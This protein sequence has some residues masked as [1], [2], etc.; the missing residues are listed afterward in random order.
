MTVKDQVIEF[1]VKY[2]FQI[3]GSVIIFICGLFVA[4]ALGR[5]V[6]KSLLRFKLEPPVELLLVRVSKLMVILLTGILT[7]AKIGVDIA[8]LVA[9]VGVVGVGIGL[10]M[11]GVLG[12]LVAGL[13][14]IFA[15]PFRVG[16]F[17]ELHNESGVVNTIDLFATKLMHFDKSVVVIPNRKIVGEILH[18][19]GMIRQLE[20]R[21]GVSYHSDLKSVERV[22]RQ[23]L[24]NNAKVLKEP[25][26]VYTIKELADFSIN[27]SVK[28]WV[29][30]QDFPGTPGELY[31]AIIDAFREN[32]IEIPF[33]QRELRVLNG[34]V[35]GARTLEE[36]AVTG[37]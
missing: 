8:P 25:A 11:Q 14:I 21:I 7:V 15:K 18:N 16:E 33:P 2:G 19:Y 24:A 4:G 26:P 28:P 20:L 5:L 3:L 29:A 27:L 36:R 13:L 30:V 17:I 12:N 37:I 10:A 32:R 1:L 23:V 34:Q 35:T 22:V 9:G 6:Q 31:H